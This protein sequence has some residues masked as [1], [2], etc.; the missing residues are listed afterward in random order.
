M[1]CW[2]GFGN[3]IDFFLSSEILKFIILRIFSGCVLVDCCC[4]V[5]I[6]LFVV[7]SKSNLSV[8]LYKF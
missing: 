5:N 6:S 1:F 7:G 4:L 3:L 8:R 2:I